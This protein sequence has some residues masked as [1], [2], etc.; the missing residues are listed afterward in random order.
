MMSETRFSADEIWNCNSVK[1]AN[2]GRLQQQQ[3]KKLNHP[4][5]IKILTQSTSQKGGWVYGGITG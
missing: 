2:L 1:Q 4:E 3:K 5:R